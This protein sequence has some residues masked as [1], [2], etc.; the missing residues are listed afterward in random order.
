VIK[1]DKDNDCNYLIKIGT[2][3]EA[4]KD[5]NEPNDPFAYYGES[6]LALWTGHY[7][8]YNGTDA[9]SWF[10]RID[11]AWEDVNPC[12]EKGMVERR[13]LPLDAAVRAYHNLPNLDDEG[14]SEEV[15]DNLKR[16]RHFINRIGPDFGYGDK[17]RASGNDFTW[18]IVAGGWLPEGKVRAS[19]QNVSELGKRLKFSQVEAYK[20]WLQQNPVSKASQVLTTLV[21]S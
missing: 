21:Q 8:N 18:E 17:F 6:H 13:H 19:W 7:N 10:A 5:P 11:G 3:A 9:K 4:K 15:S 16:A 12:E 14:F 1:A 2:I 20:R